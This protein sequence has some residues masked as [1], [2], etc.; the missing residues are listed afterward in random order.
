MPADTHALTALP[1]R[2]ALSERVNHPDYLVARDPRIL[3]TRRVT[4][5]H[6]GITVADSTSLNS[7]SHPAGA[8]FRNLT[9]YDLKRSARVGNLSST[10]LWHKQFRVRG[11]FALWMLA[12]SQIRRFDRMC[13][14]GDAPST[15]YGEMLDQSGARVLPSETPG[16]TPGTG[17]LPGAACSTLRTM[18]PRTGLGSTRVLACSWP[19]SRRTTPQKPGRQYYGRV[20]HNRLRCRARAYSSNDV[21]AV[22]SRNRD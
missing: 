19:A 10:H 8:G 6:H 5:L 20:W 13:G 2:D 15:N 18:L 17:M 16:T 4:L 21:V 7:N 1:R 12:S 9:F 22:S 11:E 3:Q 14:R